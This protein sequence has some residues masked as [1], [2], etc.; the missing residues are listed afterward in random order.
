[1]KNFQEF[2]NHIQSLDS[3]S[4]PEDFAK[5]ELELETGYLTVTDH[6]SLDATRS[7]Y[8]MCAPGGKYHGKLKPILG[9]E[10]YFRDDDDTILAEAGYERTA[11][12]N[13]QGIVEPLNWRETIKYCHATLHAT[14]EQAFF[15]LT[16]ILSD[17]DLR[18]EKH[19]SERK[20][21][22]TWANLEELGAHNVTAGSGCLI[23]MVGRH[24]MQNNDPK[25]AIKYY[26]KYRSCFKPGNFFVELMPHRTDKNWVDEVFITFHDGTISRFKP[27][28]NL[29]TM[30]KE[31]LNAEKL[32][33]AFEKNPEKA[34]AEHQKLLATMHYRK[35][36]EVEPKAIKNVVH[37]NGFEQNECKP[38]CADGDYQK[39]LNFF[40]VSLARKYNDPVVISSDAHFATPD[41]KIV[42]DV[43]LM[44][45]GGSWRFAESHHRMSSAEAFANFKE[46]LGATEAE[47][48][49]WLENNRIWASKFD[50]FK[51]S[52]RDSIPSRFYP[53]DTLG[54]TYKLIEKHGRMNWNDPVWVDR[55]N[56]EIE[57][58]HRN[59]TMDLLPYFMIDEEV[60]DLYQENRQLTGPG[61]GSAAG[62]GLSY[63]LNITHVDPIKHKLSLDRFLT[64]DRILTGKN[65]DI[66]QDL[67]SRDLLEGWEE[68]L[69]EVTMEDGSTKKVPVDTMVK[70]SVGNL[71]IK[72]AFYRQ[73]DVVEFIL[74]IL[75]SE[76][77]QYEDKED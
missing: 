7:V 69:L 25:T 15:K 29:K 6:G 23:G 70:T 77:P 33:V 5:R 53:E 65:P 19:G 9:C 44:Q 76:E 32:A 27:Y 37:K 61:R 14:D 58:L 63:L 62:V 24:L 20:P 3:A 50:N 40:L 18:A 22:F 74:P 41:Y 38:W 34:L 17:A 57:L 28:K 8:D 48:E 21:L 47:F 59:G 55:L 39:D 1:M 54:H 30:A 13:S 51:F 49:G 31:P 72:E 45:H 35:W 42:Q 46:R 36:T 68:N 2:H 66:D 56:Q 52:K 73:L 67:P 11:E 4:T 12:T 60:C 64:L 26:E 75:Q 16:K 43:R 10:I 71:P